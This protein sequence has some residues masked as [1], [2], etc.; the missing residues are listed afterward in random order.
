MKRQYSDISSDNAGNVGNGDNA[1]NVGNDANNGDN[2]GNSGNSDNE[3]RLGVFL[4]D[5]ERKKIKFIVSGMPY[6][7]RL[8]TNHR[9]Y[10]D[11]IG[12]RTFDEIFREMYQKY[13]AYQSYISKYG[14]SIPLNDYYQWMNKNREL[15]TGY[16]SDVN[17]FYMNVDVFP[18]HLYNI[19]FHRY[20][21]NNACSF[22][23]AT[24]AKH[25]IVGILILNEIS[26]KND[27]NMVFN[28]TLKILI[29]YI[30]ST[31]F[32]KNLMY[33]NIKNML[34]ILA[35]LLKSCS[36][37]VNKFHLTTLNICEKLANCCL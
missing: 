26:V 30:R 36:L 4:N 19:M 11:F 12:P 31:I 25:Y 24:K 10:G 15:Y 21:M 7:K 22:S 33:F 28:S 34:E 1:G 8:C 14:H 20:D 13:L 5:E 23:D 3:K 27:K 29:K 37:N 32:S 18:W 35:A 2:A 16:F 6:P 17:N 9:E